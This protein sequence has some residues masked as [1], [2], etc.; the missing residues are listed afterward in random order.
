MIRAS[1]CKETEK[2]FQS[3]FSKLSVALSRL[4]GNVIFAFGRRMRKRI[5]GMPSVQSV[6]KG[7]KSLLK[8]DSGDKGKLV[9]AKKMS[10]IPSISYA[11]GIP[12]LKKGFSLFNFL[13]FPP[14]FMLRSSYAS[15]GIRTR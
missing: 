5:K 14:D 15:A 6:T 4:L 2:I 13:E 1:K 8:P 12:Q 7:K 9:T 3:R 11:A 10:G